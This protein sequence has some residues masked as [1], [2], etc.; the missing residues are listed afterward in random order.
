M[1]PRHVDQPTRPKRLA[2]QQKQRQRRAQRELEQALRERAEQDAAP[3]RDDGLMPR[4][5]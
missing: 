1:Q 5:D 2:Q 3:R 4:I